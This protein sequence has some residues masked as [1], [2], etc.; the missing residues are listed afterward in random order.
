MATN[1][2]TNPHNRTV[3]EDYD[4]FEIGDGSVVIYDGAT[5]EAWIKSDRAIALSDVV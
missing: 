5:P 3:S 1:D 4:S 2:P